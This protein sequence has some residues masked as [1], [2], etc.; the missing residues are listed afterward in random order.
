MPVALNLDNMP[1]LVRSIPQ[2]MS[3]RG[4]NVAGSLNNH[5]VARR[6][7]L[8]GEVYEQQ[9]YERFRRDCLHGMLLIERD[10]S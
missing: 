7:T 1:P 3:A 2:K 4:G 8:D 9:K 10:H 5:D 6:G